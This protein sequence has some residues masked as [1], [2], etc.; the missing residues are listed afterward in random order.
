VRPHRVVFISEIPTPYRTPLLRAVAERPEVDLLVLFCAPAQPDRPWELEGLGELPHTVMSGRR[1]TLRSRRET[2]VYEFN[3]GVVRILSARRPDAVV[4]GGYAVFAEQAAI[5][6]ARL[7]GVPYLLHSESHLSKP[8][9]GWKRALKR[10]LLPRIVGR[11][12]AGLAA[13]SAARRYLAAYGLPEER[14]RIFPNTVDVD[15][16]R[17][18][19]DEVRARAA[20]ERSARGLPDRYVFYAGR[21]VEGKGVLDLLEAHAALGPEAPKLVVAGEGP[22]LAEVRRRSNVVAC[23]FVQPRDLVP[24][25]ALAELTVVPS[26][27]ESWGV[28][29]NEALACGCPVVATDAVGAVED[30]VRPGVDGLVVSPGDVRALN[31]ALREALARTDFDPGSGPIRGWTY[32]FGVEQFLEALELALERRL[33]RIQRRP[34]TRPR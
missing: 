14:V 7:R 18:E 9:S 29:V 27:A 24:F 34:W 20:A 15:A 33:T 17:H 11:A 23:G 6:W 22:L 28:A 2:F 32:D 25:F 1:I 26:H 12:A 4:V 30:L 16:Y 19:A 13:G 3:P 5:A 10:A 31:A 8:R 21:L